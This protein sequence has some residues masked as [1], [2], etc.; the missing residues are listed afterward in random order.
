MIV[1]LSIHHLV[2]ASQCAKNSRV[3]RNRVISVTVR[4]WCPF[5]TDYAASSLALV[6][7]ITAQFD[8]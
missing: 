5:Y 3:T 4:P 7:W 2:N 1:F 8:Q 6:S